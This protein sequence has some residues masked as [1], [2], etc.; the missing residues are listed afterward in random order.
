[1]EKLKLCNTCME[2]VDKLVSYKKEKMCEACQ[3]Y[4]NQ[5]DAIYDEDLRDLEKYS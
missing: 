5:E 1:M 4:F 2:Y 3:D